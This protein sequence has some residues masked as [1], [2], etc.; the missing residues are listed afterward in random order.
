M[1]RAW[2]ALALTLPSVSFAVQID[3]PSPIRP[4]ETAQTPLSENLRAP[5]ITAPALPTSLPAAPQG[6]DAIPAIPELP[7]AAVNP[8]AVNPAAPAAART[9]V[10]AAQPAGPEDRAQNPDQS[11]PKPLAE[12]EGAG[13]LAN[14]VELGRAAFDGAGINAAA[15]DDSDKPAPAKRSARKKKD[16]DEPAQPSPTADDGGGAKYP[17]R[18]VRFISKLFRSVLFRPN[19]PVE[20]EIVR[21]IE[22]AR[23]SI[24]I[25]LYEFKQTAVLKALRDARDRGVQVHV[26][27]DYKQVFPEPQAQDPD[28]PSGPKYTPRVSKE[29]WALAREGFNV[30]VLKGMGD[31]GINHNKIAV[32][33]HGENYSMGIFGSYNWNWTAEDEHYENANF[34]T[35]KS[36]IGAMKTYWDWL[37]KQAQPINY[38]HKRGTIELANPDYQWPSKVTV[39]P[40]L[41]KSIPTLKFQGIELPL[42]VFSPN[43]AAGES[44]EDRMVQAIQ[45][46]SKIKDEKKRTIDVSIFALRSTKIAEA[47][48]AAQKAGTKVR[49]IIDERQATDPDTQKVFGIYAQYLA[50]NGVDVRTLSGP[51]PE[52]GYKLAQKDHNKL[53]IFAGEL[54]ET[55]SA[56]YTTYAAMGNYENGNFLDDPT[57]VAAYNFYY[58]HLWKKS[59]KLDY[60]GAAPALPTHAEL[61][62]EI[63]KP[64]APPAPGQPGDGN[65]MKTKARDIAFNGEVFPS[66]AFRPETPIEPL[67]IKAI[68][69]A[70][71]SIR[72]G[73][74]EF[75]LDGVLE[76]LKEAR[77]K[78]PQMRIEIVIDRSHVYTTGK[79]HTGA[80][81]KPSPEIMS[82]IDEGFDIKILKG[83][84]NGIQH[85]KYGVF[86][87]EDA[88]KGGGLVVFGSYNWAS[89][90]EHNH[91]ENVIFSN[92]AARVDNYRNYFDYQRGVASTVDRDKLEEV[93]STG[94][95]A[96]AEAMDAGKLAAEPEAA[97][98]DGVR[99]SKIPMPPMDTR[100]PIDLNGEKFQ[101]EYYSPQGGILDAWLRAIKA[102]KSSIDIGMFGFYSQEAAEAVVAAIKQAQT[103]NRDFKARVVLDAAQSINSKI[104]GTP[105]A[106]WFVEHGVDVKQLAGPNEGRDP[107]FEKQHSKFMLIDNKFLMTGSFN[108]SGAAENFNFENENVIVDPTDVAG[109]V[110]WFERLYQ[111]GW[112][113]RGVDGPAPAKK[114]KDSGSNDA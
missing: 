83:E 28:N 73:L 54:V 110:E 30:K 84:R 71:K 75:T 21:A 68:G 50:A 11:I 26:V 59:K 106:H 67:L 100:T 98:E 14:Q 38:N 91:F 45:A 77:R 57:D 104:D 46:T 20:P 23:K 111:R 34:T 18:N 29:I 97:A 7:A 114:S 51:D 102:A 44:I 56:N 99:K 22:T 95:D 8:A 1:Q 33:D 93:L 41:V 53:A 113:P 35:D 58:E 2:L 70:K 92:E 82:L 72:L 62:A 37:N 17:S 39:P 16:D 15:K 55:G 79:D 13:P 9:P 43:R 60:T 76:A 24:H 40:A 61:E 10:Q 31:F 107:M 52:G 27:L 86:D 101:L 94:H 74:Y 80:A 78:N 19:V 6:L 108:L 105:V 64:Q 63:D 109:F 4:I 88:A 3:G 81:R 112:A 87:A 36:R 96:E 48:V 25:A 69:S 49:V 66:F 85:N 32:L 103:D 65:P 42:I 5:L 90:A 89:T 47:L 12:I